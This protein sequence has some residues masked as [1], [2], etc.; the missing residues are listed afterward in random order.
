MYSELKHE[1]HKIVDEICRDKKDKR[2]LYKYLSRK[3]H[4]KGLHFS[5]MTIEQLLHSRRLLKDLKKRW[6]YGN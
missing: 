2:R 3:M 6:N 4:I 5:K 1:C